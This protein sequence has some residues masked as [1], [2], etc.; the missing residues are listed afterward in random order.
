[1]AKKR[2]KKK[3]LGLQ[4]FF[5]IMLIMCV[6]FSAIS[7]LLVVG[8]IPTLV[9]AI[10]D[11]TEGRVRMWSVGAMNFAGCAPFIL[12]VF[13]KGN[14]ITVAMAYVLQPRT[15]VVM[16]F[17]AGLGYLIDWAMTGI[18][19]S[20]MVQKTKARLIEIQKEQKAMVERWGVEVTGAIPLD[21]YGFAKDPFGQKADDL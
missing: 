7:I 16:Y 9:A 20:I 6:M 19:S 1:M 2:K 13:K 14:E 17:A 4:V 8:M 21:E 10:I 5:I 15:I 3:G 18:V 12:E 11:K